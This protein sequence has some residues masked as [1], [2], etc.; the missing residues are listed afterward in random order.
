[1]QTVLL[2]A[3]LNLSACGGGGGGD[4]SSLVNKKQDLATAN[5]V[6]GP[7]FIG[8]WETRCV[9]AGVIQELS[10][11]L[12]RLPLAFTTTTYFKQSTQGTNKF[13]VRELYRLYRDKDC[14]GDPL[15]TFSYGEG[16]NGGNRGSV[17]EGT[18]FVNKEPSIWE[19]V[20]SSSNANPDLQIAH[21]KTTNPAINEVPDYDLFYKRI[22][23]LVYPVTSLATVSAVA[24]TLS[25]KQSVDLN[26]QLNTEY[27]KYINFGQ[28]TEPDKIG[29]SIKSL[30]SSYFSPSVL[31]KEI[32][33]RFYPN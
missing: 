24:I 19:F 33:T 23:N 7:D 10:E 28:A 17:A 13:E 22:G 25:S 32:T 26:D 14:K 12:D 1:M 21:F 30:L 4:D 20:G 16:A 29:D 5:G 2:I 9:S 8:R 6:S 15:V 31:G 3:A 18:I 27:N 11:K